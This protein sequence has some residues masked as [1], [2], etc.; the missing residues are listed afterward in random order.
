MHYSLE[1]L[2]TGTEISD[3][4][5]PLTNPTARTPALLRTRYHNRAF[6]P[7]SPELGIYRF[8]DWLPIRRRLQGSSAPVTFRSEELGRH[9]GLSRLFITFSGYWPERGTRML[10]GTFKECE[11]FSVCARMPADHPDTLVVASAGNTARAFI[12]VCSENGIPLVVVAPERNL[13][14]L[15]AVGPLAEC[16]RLI[17]A[18]GDSDYADAIALS[19]MI[20]G[21]P[22]FTAEGGAR[23][24]ARRDG[25]GTTMLSAVE[26]IGELPHHYFQAVGSG[27][28]AI[29]A[30][31][32]NLR[33]IDNGNFGRRKTRLHVSQNAP[34]TPI[35]DAWQQ[36]SRRFGP[37]DEHTARSQIAAIN[38]RVLA[39]RNPPYGIKG[40]LYDALVDTDGTTAAI[41]NE[42]AAEAS[43]LF[44]RLEG[45]DL[46]PAAAVAAAHLAEAARVGT[47]K[48]D[49]A[50]VLNVT[51]GGYNRVHRD[52]EVAPVPPSLII[53]RRDFTPA[54]VAAAM[55]PFSPV[56]SPSEKDQPRKNQSAKDSSK[57][58]STTTVVPA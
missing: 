21:L 47:V 28:G 41:T 57:G 49:D 8:A 23:N 45:I 4:A 13:P 18:G 1:C 56:L 6:S 37:I 32:A 20:A 11:A 16:V 9:L 30:W 15:W 46:E 27:T 42:A 3:A 19:E 55:A 52:A 5:L 25:M 33:F 31:E 58:N 36:R 44:E 51:G 34:F 26:A 10:T 50:I 35:H 7:G 43:R 22:G 12:R 24:V 48:A 39:N 2:D 53:E 17:A 54:A 38:A 29:A 40:G 14:A